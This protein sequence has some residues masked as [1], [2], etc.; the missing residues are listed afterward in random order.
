[1]TMVEEQVPTR[2][3]VSAEDTW[4]IS[5]LYADQAA[6]EADV[7]RISND[8]LPALTSLQGSL[9]NGP[10]ALLAVFQAQEALG[11]VLEQIYVY[12]SLR[13]DEDTANQ[14]HQALEE[15][16]TALSIKASAAT[17]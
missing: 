2:E 9:A 11:M 8:L 5:S 13:A 4:D 17:S 3:E 6:W 12:A 16:A 14:H 7:E 15:R 10:E 1:M